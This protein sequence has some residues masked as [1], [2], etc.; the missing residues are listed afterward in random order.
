MVMTRGAAR[1]RIWAL[2]DADARRLSAF[3]LSGERSP[4]TA[5]ESAAVLPGAAV[6]DIA[7]AADPRTLD[8]LERRRSG[9]V[10]R[11]RRL[12]RTMLL[13]ADVL[14]LSLAFFV[15]QLL[16]GRDP[17][18]REHVHFWAEL[19]LFAATLPAWVRVAD[20][21]GLYERDEKHAEHTTVDE[22]INFFHL[23]TVGTWFFFVFA[24]VSG[25]A[26]PSLAKLAAFWV[27]AITFLT[28]GRVSARAVSRRRLSYLQNAVIVGAGEVG[29]TVARKFLHHAEYGI[30]VVGF[31]DSH[32][33]P[34]P[35]D[36]ASVAVLGPPDRLP[37]IIQ[38]F[39]VERVVIAFS[40]E[41]DERGLELIRSLARLDVQIDIVPRFFDAVSP[42][43]G[44]HTIEGL[45]LVG[46]PP[47]RVSRS[48]LVVK[49]ALDI[50]V[51][52]VALVLLAPLFAYLALR[53]KLD[54]PG[55]V[56]YRHERIG[57]NG[58]AFKLV[59]FRTMRSEYCR[60]EEYGGT[61]AERAFEQL[62]ANPA[63]QA[64]FE[65]TYKL[66]DDPRVTDFG[67]FLR[68]TSLDELP[69]LFNVL[70]GDISLVGPRPVTT[71]ELVRYG[72]HL[73]TVLDV[74]PGV[75]GYWQINGRSETA[76][77]ERVRLDAAYVRGW[78][79]RLDLLILAK[80]LRVLVARI[81]AY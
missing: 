50:V 7:A 69:Q 1:G 39:D 23:V 46:L 8:I 43:F 54:S 40:N 22:L 31:V 20:L 26:E 10:P 4:V 12:V 72:P 15:A 9:E 65:Q 2:P 79:L 64:E 75:T 34:R 47:L 58:G 18:P 6:D 78:S 63:R 67:Q 71:D 53:V 28:V 73:S 13:L 35:D 66:R 60:G 41:S 56:F 49:R 77:D 81:G 44:V 16:F 48:V 42:N 36:L 55:R 52:T 24:E 38:V 37:E 76:Y 45:P 59:K 80:T 68:R 30:N 3:F 61:G 33:K 5:S 19:L 21:Y 74:R 51:A 14:A 27:L 17:G 11:R 70:R 29:Q 32:P 25:L 57:R 62:M